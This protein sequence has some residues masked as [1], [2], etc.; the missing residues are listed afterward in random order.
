[1]VEPLRTCA[2]VSYTPCSPCEYAIGMVDK[3]IRE[4]LRRFNTVD[5][6]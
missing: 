4:G 3:V 5:P 6:L 2:Q 1:M